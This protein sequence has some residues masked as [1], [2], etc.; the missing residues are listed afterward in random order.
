MV[1]LPASHGAYCF[2]SS[3]ISSL[4]SFT[5]RIMTNQLSIFLALNFLLQQILSLKNDGDLLTPSVSLILV[6]P[7]HFSRC[8]W[9]AL[10]MPGK[11]AVTT[12][13]SHD[14]FICKEGIRASLGFLA[15]DPAGVLPTYLHCQLLRLKYS[16]DP[17]S[18]SAII[19]HGITRDLEDRNGS[20][21]LH[22]LKLQDKN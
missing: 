5:V 13:S 1:L 18:P 8:W 15:L 20:K 17:S 10:R 2:L 14:S 11:C 9:W 4:G 16:V 12:V 22:L 6:P 19:T 7:G 21:K 3:L